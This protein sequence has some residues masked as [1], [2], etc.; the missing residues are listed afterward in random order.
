MLHSHEQE[1]HAVKL[2]V[3]LLRLREER[4]VLWWVCLFVCLSVCPFA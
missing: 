1:L 3:L 4:K 2:F